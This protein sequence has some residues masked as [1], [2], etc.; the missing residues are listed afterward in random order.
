MPSADL[1]IREGDTVPILTD[2]ILDQNGNP[3]TNLS[4]V[5][6]VLRSLEAPTPVTLTGTASIV[7]GATVQYVWSATDTQ[8]AGAGLFSAEWHCT[9][10]TGGTY[11]F[12]NDGYRTISIE[13]SLIDIPQSLVSIPD[14][15]DVLNIPAD[16]DSHDQKILRFLQGVQV[17]VEG[18]CGPMVPQLIEEWHE[19]GTTSISLRRRP[20]TALGMSPI[21]TLMACSEY[22][23]PIEWPLTIVQSPDL[24]QLYSCMLE[25]R[26]G[27]VVRR[28]AGGGVQPFADQ[29]EQSVHVIYQTGQATIPANIYE[30]TLEI[31]RCFYQ[32]GQQGG[33]EA[34]GGKSSDESQQAGPMYGAI[35]TIVRGWIGP[36]KKYPRLA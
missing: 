28:T 34:W 35:S 16:D 21:L 2:T 32:T 14:A 31:V 5:S 4:T 27:R 17:I 15:K 36:A 8:L 13:P 6:L 7:F 24:G 25:T 3:V 30:G 10:T 23:G 11:T 19:G 1:F 26:L 18:I 20:S 29:G 9:L 33:N 12:P 22:M